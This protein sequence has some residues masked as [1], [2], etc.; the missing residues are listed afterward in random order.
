MSAWPGQAGRLIL[1]LLAALGAAAQNVVI[2]QIYGG[3]GNTGATLRN[4]FIELFNR[5]PA[6]VDV[7]GWSVQYASSTGDTWQVTPLT[8]SIAPGQ[9]YLI[10]QAQGA[11]GSVN[12][13]APDTTGSIPMSAT[14]GKVALVSDSTPLSGAAP[15]GARIV[16]LVVYSGLSNATALLRRSAGCGDGFSTG[17]P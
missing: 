9:Y 8:G 1:L 7:T 2:S 5:G 4:D 10:Q 13:P 11:G 6:S 12:L 3:G 17:A 16:D 14:A 15:T